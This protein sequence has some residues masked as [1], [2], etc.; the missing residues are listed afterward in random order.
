MS[1]GRAKLPLVETLSSYYGSVLPRIPSAPLP[2][3]LCALKGRQ[4]LYLSTQR[5][6]PTGN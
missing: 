5:H 6:L 4:L 2:P 3:E 1:P